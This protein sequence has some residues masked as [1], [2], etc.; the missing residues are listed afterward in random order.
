M[1]QGPALV[2]GQEASR[3]VLL[4]EALLV[5]VLLLVEAL[6]VLVS[7]PSASLILASMARERMG[8]FEVVENFHLGAEEEA[9]PV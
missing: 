3:L 9:G 4:T 8:D 5:E 2:K 7:L 6:L 1:N